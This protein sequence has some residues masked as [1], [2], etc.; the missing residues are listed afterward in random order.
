MSK[1][2]MGN[3]VVIIDDSSPGWIKKGEEKKLGSAKKEKEP[4]NLNDT[5]FIE[6]TTE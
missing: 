4:E 2:D 1:K 6:N 5:E 3:E